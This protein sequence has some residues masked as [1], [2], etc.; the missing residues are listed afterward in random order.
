MADQATEGQ[1]PSPPMG[2]SSSE[3]LGLPP[4]FGIVA[5]VKSDRVLRTGAKVWIHRCNG[6]AECPVVSGLNKSGR[7]LTKYT[8]YKRLK[9]FRAAWV[10]AHMRNRVAWAWPEKERAADLA[11]KLGEMWAGVRYY[12]RDG[13]ELREDGVSTSEAFRRAR[14][15]A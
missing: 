4:L 9:N 13:T 7:Y 12:S 1:Q 3:G 6:D 5:N 2:V 15:Q 10:P 8:H 11:Q 14:Q